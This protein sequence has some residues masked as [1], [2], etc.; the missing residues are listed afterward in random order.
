MLDSD[1]VVSSWKPGRIVLGS[2][3]WGCNITH[4]T[5]GSRAGIYAKIVE[6]YFPTKLRASIHTIQAG[7]VLKLWVENDF[8][9]TEIQLLFVFNFNLIIILFVLA[10]T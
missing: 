3:K 1:D 5:K 8:F 10:R 9:P 6:I 4:S 7:Y 2:S